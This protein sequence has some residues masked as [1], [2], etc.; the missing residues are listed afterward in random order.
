MDTLKNKTYFNFDYLSRYTSTPYYYDTK[1]DKEVYGVGS[2]MNTSLNFY[3]YSTKAGDTL[4][5]IALKY[6]N[7]PT[8]WWIL[9]YFNHIIDA[10]TPLA[11]GTTIKIPNISS[12]SFGANR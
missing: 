2:L 1:N 3:S 8:Y 12:I 6:Y 10:L 5:Y 4:D 9:A 11:E 7:N